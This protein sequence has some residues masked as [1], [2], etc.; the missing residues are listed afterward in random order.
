MFLTTLLQRNSLLFL[1]FEIYQRS[2]VGIEPR[3]AG[4][5]AWTVPLRYA[6]PTILRIAHY[7]IACSIVSSTF[8]ALGF[9]IMRLKRVLNF[10]SGWDGC[11]PLR[12]RVQRRVFLL[13]LQ[14]GSF[15]I[16]HLTRAQSYLNNF[17]LTLRYAGIRAFLY[18][19]KEV[20]WQFSS[21]QKAQI[22][23]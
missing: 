22:S 14:V 21:D 7:C 8:L 4:F 1:G 9:I 6:V 13:P 2:N 10:F 3:T 17:I 20:T 18:W 19:L 16:N 23:Q 11:W 5:E 12:G 15:S